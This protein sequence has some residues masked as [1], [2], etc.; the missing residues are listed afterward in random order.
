[1]KANHRRLSRSG[2]VSLFPDDASQADKKHSPVV[3]L[4]SP[5]RRRT[6]TCEVREYGREIPTNV[7]RAQDGGEM[8]ESFGLVADRKKG[9]DDP[10]A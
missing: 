9:R 6:L 2:G 8:K 4:R 3:C 10:P 7:R 1:M 5:G